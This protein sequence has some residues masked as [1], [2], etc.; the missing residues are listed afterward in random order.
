MSAA[1]AGSPWGR[2]RG[3]I[4]FGSTG[5]TR[6]SY[7]TTGGLDGDLPMMS[8]SSAGAGERC[9]LY[10]KPDGALHLQMASRLWIALDL[11][12]QWLVLT[13]DPARAVDLR[14]TGEPW[15]QSW[16]AWTGSQWATVHYLPNAT[17]PNL[18][19][20]ASQ[21]SSSLFAPLV[22]TPSLDV[23]QSSKSGVALD[24]RYVDLTDE[25][26]IG[27]DLTGSDFCEGL[28]GG[29][30]FT[31]STLADCLFRQATMIGM[32]CDQAVLDRADFTEANLT[33][34]AWGTPRSATGLILRGSAAAHSI[35]GNVA[36]PLDCTGA[37]LS[38]ADLRG[39][40]LSK[41]VLTDCQA[42]GALLSG[43]KLDGAILDGGDLRSAVLNDASLTYAS[44]VDLRGQ[45]ACFVRANLSNA[46]LSSAQLGVG[47]GESTPLGPAVLRDAVCVG[48]KG[49]S[50]SLP[51][52]DLRG[53][54]WYGQTA[55]LVS[56]DL[57]GASLSG[58]LLETLNLSKAS[59]DGA[60]FS[61]A[62][63]VQANLS[64]CRFGPGEV[65][66]AVS[67]EG[68]LLLGADLSES[69]L[70]GG[71]L[72]DA[73]VALPHGAPLFDLP[74]SAA[75]AL[76]EGDVASLAP[77]FE[78]AGYPLGTGPKVT[79]GASWLL[80]NAGDP[81]LQAPRSY[82]A[83]RSSSGVDVY[84][85]ATMKYLFTLPASEEV[86]FEAAAASPELVDAFA[87]MGFSLVQGAP[88][89]AQPYWEV[90][91]GKALPFAGAYAFPILR[92]FVDSDALPVFG[93]TK[94]LLRDFSDFPL[95]LAFGATIA[96]ESALNPASLG[97]S[98]DP[99]SW[100]EEGLS[101]WRSLMT[102]KRV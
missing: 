74:L 9:I 99:C 33:G 57:R 53:V 91:A 100:V 48:A 43:A 88:I 83:K 92:V 45:G 62:V 87:Q 34:V 24:F 73:A 50:A 78:A 30:T 41:L 32:T 68:A 77:A 71:L 101:D 8:A 79:P 6:L 12:L 2:F 72:V 28:L 13:E 16:Q 7:L 49:E 38:R 64:G 102:V 81:D 93:C 59:V 1:G 70:L 44:M 75:E 82:W 52:V 36:A 76:N 29:V 22:V 98:G 54:K 4:A 89:T 65:G 67:F 80:D 26:L 69:S 14:L 5:G 20:I 60:D 37:D 90:N 23:I 55:S 86:C 96:L 15:G 94:V 39:A 10:E 58:A 56:A 84:H 35:L 17:Q 47:E 51:G 18:T 97:P 85:G 19:L 21:S 42:A 25:P 11:H 61:D 27:V 95:G 31:G 63:L 46:D 40:D 66:R 3:K